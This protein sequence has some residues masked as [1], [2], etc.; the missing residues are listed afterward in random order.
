MEG[1]QFIISSADR[2]QSAGRR[3]RLGGRRKDESLADQNEAFLRE[4]GLQQLVSGPENRSVLAPA[5]VAT[6]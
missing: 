2:E 4:F 3:L 1:S 6:K 5:I